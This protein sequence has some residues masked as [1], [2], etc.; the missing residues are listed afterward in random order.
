MIKNNNIRNNTTN[1]PRLITYTSTEKLQ[2]TKLRVY[3][4]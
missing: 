4:K 1:F 2:S 3:N